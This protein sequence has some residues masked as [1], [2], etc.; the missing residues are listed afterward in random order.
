M[1]GTVVFSLDFELGW[2]HTDIRPEYV[3]QLRSKSSERFERIRSLIDAFDE[4]EIPA[5]WAVVGKLTESGDDP[6]FHNPSLFQYLLNADMEHDIGLHSYEHPSFTDIS[7]D[8]A[9]SD[10]QSGI[11]A[12]QQWGIRPRSFIYPQGHISHIQILSELGLEFYRSKKPPSQISLLKQLIL[13][14][15]TDYPIKDGEAEVTPVP[16]TMFLAAR[17]PNW[18]RKWRVSRALEQAATNGGLV[19]LWLHPHNVVSRPTTIDLIQHIL[20]QIRELRASGDLRCVPMSRV[21]T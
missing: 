3:C 20:R 18:H 14:P 6:L 4:Y 21:D 17:R 16:E 1:T 7:E 8:S 11:D 12:L 5:T 13:P 2:G 9:R 10:I 15:I 19:H